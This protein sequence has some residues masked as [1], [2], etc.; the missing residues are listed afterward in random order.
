MTSEVAAAEVAPGAQ[1]GPEGDKPPDQ[2][3][4]VERA[5]CAECAVFSFV[6]LVFLRLTVGMWVVFFLLV[7]NR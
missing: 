2:K 3:R 5:G 4:T 7:I 6:F 1:F